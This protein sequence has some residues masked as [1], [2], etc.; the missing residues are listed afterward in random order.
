MIYNT[1]VGFMLGAAFCNGSKL[2]MV[3]LITEKK[4]KTKSIKEQKS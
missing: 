3:T 2:G 1:I 4:L